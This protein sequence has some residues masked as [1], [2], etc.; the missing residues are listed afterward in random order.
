MYFLFE[1]MGGGLYC[2]L[3]IVMGWERVGIVVRVT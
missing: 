2:G 3:G 1:T